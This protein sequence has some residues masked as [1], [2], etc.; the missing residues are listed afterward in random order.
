LLP[1]NLDS[2]EVLAEDYIVNL[3]LKREDEALR[4]REN[5]DFNDGLK[6]NSKIK[7]MSFCKEIKLL[8]G[9]WDPG[10]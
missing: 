9:G 2:Q 6:F 8:A 4:N 5:K 10:T 7:L 1:L 3:F